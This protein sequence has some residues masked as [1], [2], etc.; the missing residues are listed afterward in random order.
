[1]VTVPS[2]SDPERY[3][4]VLHY[5][6]DMDWCHLVPLQASGVFLGGSFRAGRP[7]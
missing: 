1:V 7:R 2:S 4:Y 5:I 6:I 3:Y